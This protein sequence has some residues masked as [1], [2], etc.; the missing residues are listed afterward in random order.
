MKFSFRTLLPAILL[1][2][3]TGSV[4]ADLPKIAVTDL[5]Y[6]ESVSEYVQDTHFREKVSQ[7]SRRNDRYREG[8]WSSQGELNG[9]QQN[10]RE[11]AYDASSGYETH[12][13]IGELRKFTADIKGQLLKN[14]FRLVQG[15]PWTPKHTVNLQDIIGRIKQGYYPGADYVL[16]GNLNN[17]EFRRNDTPIQGST[18]ISHSLSMA[19]VGEFSLINTR[20]FEVKSAFSAMGEGNDTLLST[21]PGTRMM[22]NR[23]KVIQEVSR[24]LGTAVASELTNQLDGNLRT[25]R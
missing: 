4:L 16:W 12:V 5:S 17:M 7:S 20:T 23:S 15:R 1:S 2:L 6:E 14:G 10:Q 9:Q 13:D 11:T 24:S 18:A 22:L 8:D 25:S 21:A 19:L 3:A